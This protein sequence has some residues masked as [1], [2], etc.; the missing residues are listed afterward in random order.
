MRDLLT[1]AA[2]LIGCGALGGWYSWLGAVMLAC[3]L[4]VA[5]YRAWHTEPAQRKTETVIAAVRRSHAAPVC[6]LCHRPAPLRTIV[7]GY[8]DATVA[9]L[10]CAEVLQ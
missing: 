6:E 5:A 4:A 1:F 8:D 2:Y 9:C 10:A 3:A 7:P